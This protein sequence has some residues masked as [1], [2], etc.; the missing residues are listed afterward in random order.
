MATRELAVSSRLRRVRQL[1]RL[2]PVVQYKSLLVL[3]LE[4]PLA[5]VVRFR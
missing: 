2:E 3:A 4:R 5:S 1:H